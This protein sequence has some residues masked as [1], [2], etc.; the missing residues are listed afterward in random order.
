MGTR[1]TPRRTASGHT[2]PFQLEQKPNVA[3]MRW[4]GLLGF[5]PWKLK[6]WRFDHT[7]RLLLFPDNLL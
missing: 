3:A 2:V 5:Y 4:R 6:D 7:T 1:L